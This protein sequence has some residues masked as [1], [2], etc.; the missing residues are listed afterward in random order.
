[1]QQHSGQHLISD[2]AEEHFGW[3]TFGW[4]LGKEKCFVEFEKVIP[5]QKQL[6]ELQEKV[7]E[8]IRD[9]HPVQIDVDTY[10][11]DTD[12]PDNLPTDIVSGVLRQVKMGT[13]PFKPCCGTHVNKTSDIQCVKLMNVETIRGGNSR[14]WFVCGNRVFQ[15]LQSC[16]V[17]DRELNSLLS[18]GPDQFVDRVKKIKQQS[19]E[20]MKSNKQLEKELQQIKKTL[21]ATVDTQ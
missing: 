14:V 12:R 18:A 4:S 6:D 5:N 3:Q 7:N 10:I 9:A 21:A 11:N 17:R 16:L 19:K 20:F 15:L 1:M 13:I 2:L 8:F